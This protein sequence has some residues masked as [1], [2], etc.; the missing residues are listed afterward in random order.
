[1]AF[2]WS[3][4]PLILV[5]RILGLKLDHDT[6]PRSAGPDG[7]LWILSCFYLLGNLSFNGLAT[8]CNAGVA[9]RKLFCI[10]FISPYELAVT[11]A[12]EVLGTVI[13]LALVAGIPCAFLF[14]T[15]LT[16]RWRLLWENLQRINKDMN[17]SESFHRRCRTHSYVALLLLFVVSKNRQQFLNSIPI[18]TESDSK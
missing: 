13:H 5:T 14:I 10:Y 12:K 3:W 18:F 6:T 11:C 15:L 8:W 9:L 4:K 2:E 17:L 16:N 7:F 1:M